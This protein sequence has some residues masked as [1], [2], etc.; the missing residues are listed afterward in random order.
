MNVGI[1]CWPI[2]DGFSIFD[3]IIPITPQQSQ[4][5]KKKFSGGQLTTPKWLY[6]ECIG[7]SIFNSIIPLFHQKFCCDQFTTLEYHN[8][9]IRIICGPW[10]YPDIHLQFFN[11]SP[12]SLQFFYCSPNS[13]KYLLVVYVYILQ[14]IIIIIMLNIIDWECI[15][16]D[17]FSILIIQLFH[18]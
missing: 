4:K 16:R 15:T 1:A 17:R 9:N 7:F 11:Y 2:R 14:M 18:C 5:K 13:I 10:M 6:Q 8:I 3:S 12:N